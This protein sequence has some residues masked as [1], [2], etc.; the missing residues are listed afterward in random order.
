MSLIKNPYFHPKEEAERPTIA[1]KQ[2]IDTATE[3][4][5]VPL[6]TYKE[7]EGQPIPESAPKAEPEKGFT[8]IIIPAYIN[9]YPIFH[10]TGHC[11]GSIREHTDRSK[12]PFEIILVLNGTKDSIKF[13]NLAE[14]RCEKVIESEENLGY[15]KAVNKGI[16]CAKGE[17]IAVVNNDVMVFDNW[18]EDMQESLNIG[19]DL[20]MATP[21]YGKPYARATEAKELREKS[22]EPAGKSLR[23]SFSDFRDFSCVL[24]RKNMFN[25]IGLFNEEFF[26]Y[27]E[28][29]DL[30][31]RMD[32]AEKKY[33]STKR[34][35]TFHIIGGTSS[36]MEKIPE[37]MNESKAKLKEIW[38]E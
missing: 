5:T 22:F 38:G 8:S 17:Y 29:L 16:R 21:M 26:M 7:G 10:M 37:I 13:S 35:N 32:K 31:R 19:L 20:V 18:L 6:Q 1:E 9:S 14:T 12:T 27:G 11:I 23:D 24:T 36:G 3:P 34:V 15:A 28:D 30:L 33:A 4:T 25:E 2:L